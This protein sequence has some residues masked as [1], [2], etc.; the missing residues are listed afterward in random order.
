MTGSIGEVLHIAA[1]RRP[2]QQIIIDQPSAVDPGWPQTRTYAEWAQAVDE[3]AGWLY[4]LGVRAWDRVA[5][6]KDNHFDLSILACAAARIGAVP[7]LLSGAYGP[8]VAHVLLRR[9]ERPFLIA[10]SAHIAACGID[11]DAVAMLTERTVCIDGSTDRPDL[12]ALDDVRGANPPVPRLRAPDEPMIIT[13]TSG[14][15]G[16]PKLVLHSAVSER[17]CAIIESE[18]WPIIGIRSGDVWAYAEPYWHERQTHGLLAM[19]VIGQKMIMISDPL[20]VTVRDLLI[21]HRPTLVEAL[22]NIFLAWEPMAADPARPFS[23]VREYINSFDAIHVRTIRTF[24]DATDRRMPIWL[25]AWSQ[26]ENGTL[27]IRPYLRGSVRRKGRRPAPTQLLGWPVPGLGRIR[28]VHPD[29]GRPTRRGEV[30]LIEIA[31]PGRCVAYVG[32]QPRHEAKLDGKWWHTGDLG[33]INRLGALRIVDREIDRLP[34][35][36][37]IEL[38]DVLLDRLDL[39]TEVVILPVSGGLPL[40]VYSTGNDVPIDPA[41]WRRA[42]ADLPALAEPIHIRWAEF[43]RTGTWKIRRVALR[44]QLLPGSRTFGKGSWT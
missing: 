40:P 39:T 25:Q 24:L 18:R 2:D 20:A 23:N 36:S 10:D 37:A 3:T 30:G 34:Q 32:E 42:T 9:L 27:L 38:E 31:Q 29:T 33:R 14:T 28:T 6:L 21:R 8:D 11:A 22:P 26:S 5:V 16:I 43:P 19:A 12:V 7:A 1:E 17:A 41:V 35:G 44:E 15:T 13:H 4:Q